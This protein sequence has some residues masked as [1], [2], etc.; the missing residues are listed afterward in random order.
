MSHLW[1]I[2]E[3]HLNKSLPFEV[4]TTVDKAIDDFHIVGIDSDLVTTFDSPLPTE[5]WCTFS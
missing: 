1:V 2:D 4:G 3:P 5:V